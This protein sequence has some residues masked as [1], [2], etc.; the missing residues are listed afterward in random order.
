MRAWV[1]T[2]LHESLAVPFIVSLLCAAHMHV[3]TIGPANVEG[4]DLLT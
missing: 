3:T 1:S 4:P 2:D